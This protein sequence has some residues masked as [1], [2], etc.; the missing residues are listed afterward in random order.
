MTAR[1]TPLLDEDERAH[2]RRVASEIADA[3]A[4]LPPEPSTDAAQA[5]LRDELSRWTGAADRDAAVRC[6]ERAIDGVGDLAPEPS[7]FGGYAGV[8]M[9]VALLGGRVLAIPEDAAEDPCG[10]IDEALLAWVER[11]PFPRD[12][13]YDLI[14]GLVG[15]GTYALA[16]GPRPVARRLLRAVV[17]RLTALSVPQA[18][19]RAWVTPPRRAGASKPPGTMDL[20]LAHGAAGVVAMIGAA[21]GVDAGVRETGGL[22]LVHEAV[23]FL[24]AHERATGPWRFPGLVTP[25]VDP[26]SSRAAWC[27]GDPGVAVALL[28]A[29]RGAGEP[30]WE[31][32]S[33]R[34]AR[35]AAALPFDACG[36]HDGAFCHGAAGLAHMYN[37][38]HQATGDPDLRRAARAWTARTL[39]YRGRGTTADASGIGGY[40]ALFV[41]ADA[42]PR[43]A[44]DPSMVRGAAGIALVLASATSSEA[45]V[46]DHPLL[47]GPIAAP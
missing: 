26:S 44:D 5:L 39:Q 31:Q 15:F 11:D 20:G 25:G 7:L 28:I 35:S 29:A 32:A 37:R 18:V 24:L 33:L 8:A 30:A 19:G 3:L 9:A 42:P 43:W 27:Y 34:I 2:A 36:V 14:D 10:D 4:A 46:W 47:V 1:W 45:P 22:S 40:R 16:R 17:Q 13:P 21:C 38:L 12:A 23:A 6:I 41:A